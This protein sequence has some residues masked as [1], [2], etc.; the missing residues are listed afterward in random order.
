MNCKHC[1][2]FLPEGTKFCP[3]CGTEVVEEVVQPQ[4]NAQPQYDVQPQYQQYVGYEA[5]AYDQTERAASAKSAL[6]WGILG[7]AFAV[8]FYLSFLGIIFSAIAKNKVKAYVAAFGEPTA[9]VKTGN[10]L[11]TGGLIAGIV[12]TVLLVIFIIAVAGAA[13]IDYYY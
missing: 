6:T 4:Y 9:K 7:L 5:P 11:A 13:S 10:G 3:S 1:G 8:S 2:A 12:L